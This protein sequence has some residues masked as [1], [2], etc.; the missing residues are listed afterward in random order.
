MPIHDWTRVFAGLW[1]DFHM[2]WIANLRDS[3]N[4]TL[5]PPDYYALAEQ[6]TG[7][8]GPDVLT[9]Q[10][11]GLHENGADGETARPVETG[12]IDV[13]VTKPRVRRQFKSE[14]GWY[15]ARG[16]TLTVRHRSGDR[17]VAMI[18]L[19]SPGNKSRRHRLNQFVRKVSDAFE[20][21]IHL[22]V[23]DLFPPTPRD[24]RGIH[25]EIWDEM[26][27][28]PVDVPPGEPLTLASYVADPDAEIAAYV[29]TTAIGRTMIDMPLFL[30][31]ERYVNVPLDATYQA[32]FAKVPARWREV[33]DRP[34]E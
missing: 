24:P 14:A 20:Q 9:L 22:L 31:A 34:A 23:V 6:H 11:A 10:A 21:G 32:A 27:E 1:H 30:N 18:E 3:L 19:M 13:A 12:G 4:D 2:S 17:I 7:P 26:G 29:E 16:R 15:A 8:M 28:G 25:A 5:L 33:L